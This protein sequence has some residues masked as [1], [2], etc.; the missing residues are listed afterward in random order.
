M[1]CSQESVMSCSPRSAVRRNAGAHSH[2]SAICQA[3]ASDLVR[4]HGC[5]G[6]P[7]RSDTP[8]LLRLERHGDFAEPDKLR[9][10]RWSRW[11]SP[12]SL[13]CCRQLRLTPE[14]LLTLIPLPAPARAPRPRSRWRDPTAA[15]PAARFSQP[16]CAAKEGTSLLKATHRAAHCAPLA[17]SR[18]PH[19]PAVRAAHMRCHG[20][21]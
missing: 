5:R 4:V 17:H 13:D 18:Q 7:F 1:S 14:S 12:L 15:V 9:R 20:R 2:V 3:A 6:T 8:D 10:S 16:P 21:S 19:R 11:N